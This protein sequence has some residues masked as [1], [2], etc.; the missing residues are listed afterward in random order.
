MAIQTYILQCRTDK[1]VL[2]G[3]VQQ[4]DEFLLYISMVITDQSLDQPGMVT[5]PAHGQ[6]NREIEFFPVP[7]RA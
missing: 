3:T 7:V 1:N 4:N 2:V 5:N 6:L